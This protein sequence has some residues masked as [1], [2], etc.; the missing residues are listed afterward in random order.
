[1]EAD[2][3]LNHFVTANRKT[4]SATFD[5]DSGFINTVLVKDPDCLKTNHP[6]TVKNRRAVW[7][8]FIENSELYPP[9]T[10]IG[11]MI[12][13]AYIGGMVSPSFSSNYSAVQKESI[14][15]APEWLGRIK[16]YSAI[17]PN[18]LADNNVSPEE[19]VTRRAL[20]YFA[21]LLHSKV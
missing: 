2:N 13:A 11:N 6:D 18:K 10:D 7:K 14:E 1:M 9:K 19:N 15:Q 17:A 8:A 4:E 21:T 12:A 5:G 16:M 20:E 3:I